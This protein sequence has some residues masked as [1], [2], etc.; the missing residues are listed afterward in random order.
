MS[1]SNEF[2]TDIYQKLMETRMLETRLVELYAEGRIP[3]HIHSGVGQEASY[4]G[5]LANKG[6]GDWIRPSHRPPSTVVIAGT[7]LKE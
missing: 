6:E 3:G 4:V 5:V 1:Y 7:P 2:L